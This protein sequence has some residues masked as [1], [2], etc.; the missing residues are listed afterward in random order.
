[1]PTRQRAHAI[2]IA[3]AHHV[4]ARGRRAWESPAVL[5]L[6]AWI[7]RALEQAAAVQDTPRV[8]APAEEWWLWRD[9]VANARPGSI[10]GVASLIDALRRADRLAADHDI[11]VGR[12]VTLGGPETRLLLDAQRAMA[13]ACRELEAGTAVHLARHATMP[14]GRAPVHFTGFDAPDARRA[15]RLFDA[16]RAAA[17]PGEWLSPGVSL[18]L[19][20][21]DAADDAIDEVEG[22]AAWC[23]ATIRELPDSR[24]LVVAAGGAEG[25]EA[26]AARLRAA[27]AP[28]ARLAGTV[29]ADLV[30]IEGGSPLERQALV[31]HALSS[32][33]WLIEGLEFE[34][35]STWLSSPYGPLS[36]TDG[37]RLDLW[38]RRHAPLEA[39]A[40]ASL[41]RLAL[42]VA[43]GIAAAA[44]LA[45]KV[46]AAL[47][48]LDAAPA[49]AHFWSERFRAALD[50]LRPDGGTG[51][52]SAEQQAWLRLVDLFDEFGQLSRVAGR[53]DA[54]QALHVLREL[55]A[56]TTWQ[57]TTGDA[58]VTI[59]A[60]HDDPI[61]RYD[62]I[63]VAGLTADA[64]PAAPSAD[65]FIPLPALREAG[66][67]AADPARQLAAAQASL[68]AWC[69]ATPTLVLSAPTASGDMQVAPS[70]LLA[71]L[72]RRSPAPREPWLP[73]RLR[74]A[75]AL[76]E[77]EDSTG[78]AWPS[79]LP[80]PGGTRSIE[81][82]AACPF[83]AYAELQLGATSPESP[84]PGVAAQERGRWLHGA[85]EVFWQ[86][87]RDSGRLGRLTPAQ[88]D[89]QAARAV[90][91]A[92]DGALD[93]PRAPAIASRDREARRL[94]GLVAALAR[95]EQA[96]PP[97]GI[98]ALEREHR[99]E[100]GAARL[101]VRI[102]RTDLLEEGG[103]AVIDYKSGKPVPLDWFGARPT[104]AQLLVYASAF[105]G[106]VRALAY[107]R[108]AP[109]APRFQGVA[110]QDGLL[111]RVEGLAAAADDAAKDAWSRQ[112]ARWHTQAVSLAG[113]F[114][115][116]HAAVT[117]VEGACRSCHLAAL[118]RIGDAARAIGE[119][120]DD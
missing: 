64:W 110:A 113:E 6:D 32:L 33:T 76:V 28:R 120:G 92:R 82:Q 39:D 68:A 60:T 22:I 62:G 59:S 53:F 45:A 55:A 61:V 51:L 25:R 44:E 71:C 37:A 12:W 58:R 40:R 18:G 47:S 3:Y 15:R 34:A 114:L 67:V 102:D 79:H 72:P 69:A 16:R 93:P 73:L 50:A 54:R 11:D 118:C 101:T 108:V 80:L 49:G 105:D 95:L 7:E 86:E 27:L 98:E 81:L 41:E 96:R 4:L 70:P 8:L 9:A 56:R 63:W 26:I 94:A 24:L 38:W 117:P 46:R 43:G 78:R 90:A 119:G 112:L 23:L 57:A 31:H 42:A 65:P 109:P 2:R 88:L 84:A 21:V 36:R 89:E 14:G 52:T 17:L 77:L 74:R 106:N 104:A 83:R 75:Q 99:I 91:S 35:F 100:L 115:D 116:A 48:A 111:P 1:M 66:V 85:L 103:R 10:V 13:Q 107:A 20:L 87:V 5:P 19:P 30:A 29:D 97:F